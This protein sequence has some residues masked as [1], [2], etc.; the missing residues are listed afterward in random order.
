MSPSSEAC[1]I[2]DVS[3]HGGIMLKQLAL[4]FGLALTPTLAFADKD[5]TDSTGATYDCA[6]D[7][8]VNINN[9]SGTFAFTGPCKEIN[10]NGSKLIITV[11]D[12]EELNLNG[13]SN[14][15]TADVVGAIHIN[16]VKNKVTWKKAKTGKKPSVQSN[17]KGNS[18]SKAK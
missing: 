6:E 8:T 9:G 5:F 4:V 18:V 16:G 10:V 17:G 1:G 13:A 14:A 15:V 12:V 2:I 7:S 3:S 11:G